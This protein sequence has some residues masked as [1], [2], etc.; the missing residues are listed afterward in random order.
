MT[1]RPPTDPMFL[2][3]NWRPVGDDVNAAYAQFVAYQAEV[4][5][6]TGRAPLVS[7][8]DWRMMVRARLRDEAAAQ[9]AARADAP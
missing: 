9:L 5:K 1:A 2:G 8:R 3:T 7:F 6:A 4:V